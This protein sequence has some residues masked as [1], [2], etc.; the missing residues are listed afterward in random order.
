MRPKVRSIVCTP[1]TARHDVVGERAVTHAAAALG[2]RKAPVQPLPDRRQQNGVG[3]DKAQAGRLCH[4][5]VKQA[6][7]LHDTVAIDPE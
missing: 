6:I 1:S 3:F 7:T 2:V 4:T 5:K